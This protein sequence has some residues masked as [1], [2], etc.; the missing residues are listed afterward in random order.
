MRE[1]IIIINLKSGKDPRCVESYRLISLINA[2]VKILAKILANQL[3]KVILKIIHH[4]QSGFIPVRSTS[5]NIWR[6]FLNLQLPVEKESNRAVIALDIA[7]AFDCVEWN[8]LWKVLEVGEYFM[9]WIKLLY[10]NPFA[11]MGINGMSAAFFSLQRGTRQGCPLFPLFAMAME[12]FAEAL[13]S[14]SHITGFKRGA[15]EEKV[16][17]YADDTLIFLDNLDISLVSLN[18]PGWRFWFNLWSTSKLG[19]I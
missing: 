19:K 16:A 5:V 12:P 7:K 14:S 17:L 11:F 9:R 15:M 6:L 3:R 13:R 8:Y 1:A 10:R 4:D 18:G 2:D